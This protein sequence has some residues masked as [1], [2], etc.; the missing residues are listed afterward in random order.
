[1]LENTIFFLIPQFL[2]RFL[3]EISSLVLHLFCIS[4][5]WFFCFSCVIDHKECVCETEEI[6]VLI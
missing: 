6:T 4:L 3:K 1:M 5:S 2:I